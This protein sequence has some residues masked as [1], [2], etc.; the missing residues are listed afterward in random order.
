MNGTAS[1]IRVAAIDDHPL[2]LGRGFRGWI[3]RRTRLRVRRARTALWRSAW[4]TSF[5]TAVVLDV[6]LDD[7]SRPSDNVRALKQAGAS[8]SWSSRAT[9]NQRR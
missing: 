6:H 1:D 4:T 3:A 5:R 8:R 9:R 7:K 2:D